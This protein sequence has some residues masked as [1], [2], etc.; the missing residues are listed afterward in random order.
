M[1]YGRWH[2][3][4]LMAGSGVEQAR[5]LGRPCGRDAE[6]SSLSLMAHCTAGENQMVWRGEGRQTLHHR[7]ADEQLWWSN[8]PDTWPKEIRRSIPVLLFCF[9]FSNKNV[10]FFYFYNAFI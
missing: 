9:C 5:V 4:L 10:C 1:E 8:T 6:R 7:P 2:D 3:H